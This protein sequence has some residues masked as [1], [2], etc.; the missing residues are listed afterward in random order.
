VENLSGQGQNLED[1]AK[2]KAEAGELATHLEKQN[3]DFAVSIF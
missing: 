1:P 3:A 2:P